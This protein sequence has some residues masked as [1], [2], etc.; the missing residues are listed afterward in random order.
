MRVT[1][2]AIVCCARG[3]DGGALLVEGYS[4]EVLKFLECV[5]ELS[6]DFVSLVLILFLCGLC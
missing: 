4:L 6:R 1:A 2:L 3:G 5:L